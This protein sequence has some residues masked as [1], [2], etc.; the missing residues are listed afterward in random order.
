M[1]FALTTES[2]SKSF[3]RQKAVDDLSV[4]VPERSIYGFLGA[5]GA[6]KTTTLRLMRCGPRAM[7]WRTT[8]E[9]SSSATSA[10]TTKTN[11]IRATIS[12][13]RSS[14]F[15]SIDSP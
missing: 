6:G 1:A 10:R 3:G 14:N 4:R 8:S 15:S 2:L 5:N 11:V 12:R 9:S 7:S 13:C